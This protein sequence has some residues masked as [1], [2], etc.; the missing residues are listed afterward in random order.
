MKP[1]PKTWVRKQPSE[2]KN[3][4]SSPSS[5]PPPPNRSDLAD[6]HEDGAHGGGH[7]DVLH[8]L[9]G[10]GPVVAGAGLEPGL[11]QTGAVD[12]EEAALQELDDE[13][14][15]LSRLAADHPLLFG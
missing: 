9:V 3:S 7:A 15:E 8:A 11:F 5:P 1:N 14:L 4:P 12:Q 2:T 10:G 6:L 13:V